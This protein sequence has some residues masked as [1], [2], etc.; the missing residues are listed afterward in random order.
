M[1]K[2]PN[3]K[4]PDNTT[5]NCSLGIHSYTTLNELMSDKSKGI[6]AEHVKISHL[7][8]EPLDRKMCKHCP[9]VE[10]QPV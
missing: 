9:H 3:E 6:L 1:K 10:P 8:T 4:S 7:D 2:S 5:L